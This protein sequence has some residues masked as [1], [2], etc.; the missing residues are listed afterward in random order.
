MKNFL[1]TI[2]KLGIVGGILYYLISSERLNFERLLLLKDSPNLLVLMLCILIGLVIPLA[3]L[4]WWLLL[5]AIGLHVSPRRTFLLTWIGNFFNSTLP[6]AVSGDVVKGYYIIRTQAE[7][8]RTYAFMSLL[9]DRFVGLFGLIIIAFFSLLANLSI[10]L[11]NPRLHSLIWMIGLLF[12]ATT[13][14][15]ILVTW[16]FHDG[17]DPFLQLFKKLPAARFTTKIYLAFK[18][19]QHQ[20]P[21]L[22]STLLIAI[23]IH[24]LIAFLFWKIAHLLPATE[25][26]LGTQLFL[27]P[28]GLITTAIPLAPGGIGIGHV[29]FESLYQLVGVSGGA[30][31]F[32]IYIIVQLSVYL[33]GGIPYFLYNSE[34]QVPREEDVS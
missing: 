12:L 1:L 28:I 3:A 13:C 20:K 14:F 2:G 31:I 10:F 9:I 23:L 6:G 30:D 34:Y 19:Y 11:E 27:M 16:P 4:R 18:S 5:K 29:A 33:L 24:C 7:E 32:N 25:M 15:Y 8:D 21:I 17:K 22:L 26:G